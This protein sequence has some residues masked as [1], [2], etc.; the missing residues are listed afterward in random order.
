M[1]LIPVLDLQ[2]G[3]VVRGVGGRR[4]EY[5][6]LV[7]C[8]TSSVEPLDVAKSLVEAFSPHEIYIA[9]L[10]AIAGRPPSWS[11]L[12]TLDSHVDLWIDAGIKSLF[13]AEALIHSSIAG[14]VVGLE[15]VDGPNVLDV[16][17]AAIGRHRVV[18]SLD[19]RGGTLLGRW[20]R[21]H[22][23]DERDWLT[24]AKRAIQSG[25]QRLI[26]LDLEKVGEGRGTGTE[27]MC[28]TL[29]TSH[30]DVEIICGGGVRNMEDLHRLKACGASAV[31]VASVLH[32][33]RI[34][35]GDWP[36]SVTSPV[37]PPMPDRVSPGSL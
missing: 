26:L 37:A 32:D 30:P 15:T 25:I 35:P 1:R 20:Q 3:V 36:P 33:G 22:A 14:I 28:R 4:A 5:R 9:D 6:P 11:S 16:A 2:N 27:A 12:S 19:L 8:L 31:L 24:V 10:D 34:K 13:D 18:F 17:V 23:H 7:S 21:W 29:S